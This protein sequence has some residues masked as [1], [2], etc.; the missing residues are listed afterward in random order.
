MCAM[1]NTGPAGRPT[2]PGHEFSRQFDVG[3]GNRLSGQFQGD[4]GVGA[5]RHHQQGRGEL[6]GDVG[7]QRSA[8]APQR[9]P[10]DLQ[11]G[12]TGLPGERNRR[13]EGL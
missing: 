4:P 10:G 2:E 6:A 8:A 7:L 13:S 3:P 12:K 1:S 9:T 11:R 5:G